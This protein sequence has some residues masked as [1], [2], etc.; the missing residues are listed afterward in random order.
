MTAITDELL[1]A[2]ADGQ[3][4]DLDMQRIKQAMADDESLA[5]RVALFRSTKQWAHDAY[6]YAD[7]VDHDESVDNV[8]SY[9]QFKQAVDKASKPKTMFGQLSSMAMVAGFACVAGIAGFL[10]AQMVNDVSSPGFAM[11]EELAQALSSQPSEGMGA[12][13]ENG[14]RV[15]I[16]FENGDGQLC[17]Q[18]LREAG[19]AYE[20]GIAC[21]TDGDWSLELAMT[22]ELSRQGV[23]AASSNA[24]FDSYFFTHN[25][26]QAL[27]PEEEAER[28]GLQAQ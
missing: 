8:V 10:A 27:S 15:L 25:A 7:E 22:Q 6:K 20:G 28:L 14:V 19:S 2:Y 9:T 11:D 4:D 21:Q 18:Y 1:M 17:R 24:I 12:V 16:S 13:N 3:L 23:E 26:G 5:E